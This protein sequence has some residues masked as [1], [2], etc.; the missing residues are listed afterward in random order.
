[1]ELLTGRIAR[2][3]EGLNHD[4]AEGKYE[5]QVWK[6]VANDIQQLQVTWRKVARFIERA[7]GYQRQQ[8]DKRTTN[9]TTLHISD[10]VLLHREMVEA[11]WSR[12]L[13]PKWE[14]PYI[15]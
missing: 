8:N 12:K 9:I 5:D 4:T 14:G 7:Q 15:M 11:S 1:M 13:E 10:K 3:P 6:A 2:T